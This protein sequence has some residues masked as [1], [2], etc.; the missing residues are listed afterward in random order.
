MSAAEI[1]A[2][3]THD[4][5]LRVVLDGGAA[6]ADFHWF[7][8][9]HHCECCR[10]PTT[11]ERTL[12]ASRVP[13]DIRARAVAIAQHDRRAALVI[14][15]DEPGGHRSVFP[16]AWLR[17]HAY[18]V[19]R[20]AVPPPA[21]DVAA[22]ELEAAAL[23]GGAAIARRCLELLE[24]RGAAVVRGFGEDT[25]GLI[26]AFAAQDLRVVET[27]FGRIE[28]LRTDNTT[29]QNTDQLGYTDAP[30]DLHTDQPFLDEPPRYQILHCMRPAERG[31]ENAIADGRQAALY[32]ESTD[33]AA[34]AM[35][36]RVRV[37][38]HRR[39][40]AFERLVVAPVVELRDGAVHRIR[41]SYF[42]MAPHRL[43]FAEMTEWYRAYAAFT[44]LVSDPRRHY[45]FRLGRGDFLVYD[46]HRML[47][48]RTAFEGARWVRG[49]YFDR[50][51]AAERP[52]STE[53]GR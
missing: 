40:K 44:N 31:G 34:F 26:D 15:W 41:S 19:N 36:T 47:H 14:D 7:W 27:H 35:L 28:D 20:E 46:N 22:I 24:N 23:P 25:D 38:F 2:A 45:R 1:L 4:R 9:R 13:L 29:N 43:P 53:S 33:A 18:A 51:A 8:L 49:I 12:C 21:S 42:T 17:E 50:A 5:F 37:R 39:Q 32:L 6:H 11:G 30:V 3:E 10:H 16:V 48:A 52:A